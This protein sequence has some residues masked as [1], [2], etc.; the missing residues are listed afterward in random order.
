MIPAPN[1]SAPP[2]FW[3]RMFLGPKGLRAG[4][5]LALFLAM[6]TLLQV[7]AG[8]AARRWNWMGAP[9]E[10]WVPA[11]LLRLEAVFVLITGIV[12]AVMARIERHRFAD[13]GIPWRRMF[14]RRFWEGAAWGVFT[15]LATVLP[16]WAMGGYAV[17]GLAIRGAEAVRYLLLWGLAFL[18]AGLYEEIAFRG[19]VLR[20]VADGIGFWP[21]ALILSAIFGFVLH[22]LEKDNETWVDGLSVTLIALLFCWT[23]AKTGDVWL[24]TGWHFTFN[25]VSMGILGSP[26]TGSGGGQ[27]VV[28]HLLASRFSGSQLLTGWP[29]GL[30]ASLWL[31][32]AFVLTWGLLAWRFRART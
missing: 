24:A 32:P 27:P 14:G 5:R 9:G 4:W 20:T 18:M 22:Y 25:F 12:I 29:M 30:E 16:V 23:V 8:L 17:D 15:I 10:P 11:V 13:Y 21:A 7:P 28:G 6:T 1:A 3:R 19:Y 2:P 26:N 31:F